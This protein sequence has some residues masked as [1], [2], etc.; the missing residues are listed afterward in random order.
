MRRERTLCHIAA[1]A[2]S[3]GVPM[4]AFLSALLETSVTLC[5]GHAQLLRAALSRVASAS[6]RALM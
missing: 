2:A 1:V 5:R 6:F 3:S 4:A